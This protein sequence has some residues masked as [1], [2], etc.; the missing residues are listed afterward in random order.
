MSLWMLFCYTSASRIFFAPKEKK[1]KIALCAEKSLKDCTVLT[2]SIFLF[3][4]HYLTASLASFYSF[5]LITC[6]GVWVSVAVG[7]LLLGVFVL[8]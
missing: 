4:I 6:C 7:L 5:H 2:E 8:F 1:M 3:R